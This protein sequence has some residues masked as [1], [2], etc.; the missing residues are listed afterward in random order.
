MP[1]LGK[2]TD[3]EVAE[4]LHR[5][6]TGV[7]DQRKYLGIAAIACEPQDLRI[8]K[9]AGDRYSRLFATK[10]NVELEKSWA[11]AVPRG[12]PIV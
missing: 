10:S 5:T 8:E 12:S 4:K 7:R 2:V 6:L 11:G 9:A 1:L 3:R